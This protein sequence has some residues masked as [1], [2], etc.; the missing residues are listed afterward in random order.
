[1]T[2]VGRPTDTPARPTPDG[3]YDRSKEAVSETELAKDCV[4]YVPPRAS[5]SVQ[6]RLGEIRRGALDLDPDEG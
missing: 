2:T 1:M 5:F 4:P 6:A 3:G